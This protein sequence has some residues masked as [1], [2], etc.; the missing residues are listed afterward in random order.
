MEGQGSGQVSL[1]GTIAPFCD[2]VS[3]V[4]CLDEFGGWL[5]GNGGSLG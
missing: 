3:L 4:H 5:Q 1:D 2:T